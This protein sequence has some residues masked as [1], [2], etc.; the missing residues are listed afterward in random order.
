MTAEDTLGRWK[1]L[2]RRV[3]KRIDMA[4]RS[5][6]YLVAASCILHNICELRKDD[7]VEEW[8]E[9]VHNAV[10]QPD[11]IP[12]ANQREMPPTFE[13]ILQ[14]FSRHLRAGHLAVA[15]NRFNFFLIHHFHVGHNAP[16]LPPPPPHK[17]CLPLCSISLR[18]TVIP[19]R[20]WNQWLWKNW[21]RGGRGNKMHCGLCENGEWT[22]KNL[23]SKGCLQMDLELTLL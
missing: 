14:Y 8:L 22:I 7:F 16:C 18:T 1:G 13:M 23:F 2:F 17:F 11:N 21:G 15:V 6:C 19:R 5:A 20:N 12:L 9:D 4:V 3:L 10:E